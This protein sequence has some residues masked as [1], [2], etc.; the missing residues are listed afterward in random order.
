[1][2]EEHKSNWKCEKCVDS[3]PTLD[4]GA[5]D[6]SLSNITTR[7]RLGTDSVSTCH[8]PSSALLSTAAAEEGSSVIVAEMRL[9]RDDIISAVRVEIQG[10]QKSMRAEMQEFRKS[11]ASLTSA[12]GACNNRI[13]ELT[14]RVEYLEKCSSN[15]EPTDVCEFK[16]TIAALKLELNDRDQGLLSND[17]EI[18]GIPEDK[19]ENPIHLVLAVAMK[20][21]VTLEERDIVSAERVGGVLR[22]RPESDPKESLRP[23]PIVVRLARRTQR[24]ELLSAARVR[25]N[26]TTAGLGLA[27][28]E[29]RLYVNERLTRL[30]R[31]IFYKARS[32]SLRANYKYVWTR[33]GKIFTRKEHGAERHRLRSEDDI[34]I[35]FG[36]G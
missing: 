8:T 19:N 29:R 21:G 28:P 16:K 30:N 31:H 22:R 6:T 25:R 11:I 36:L 18:A 15:P 35:T 4:S 3:S 10:F 23:G 26:A 12:V 32:E 1:M 13:D 34:A 27:S 17:L 9:L 24:E 7:K 20:M 2:R 33:D 14:K 5:G